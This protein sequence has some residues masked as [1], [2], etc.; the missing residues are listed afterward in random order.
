MKFR[1]LYF[2]SLIGLASTNALASQDSHQAPTDASQKPDNSSSAQSNGYEEPGSNDLKSLNPKDRTLVEGLAN[3]L[4]DANNEQ[5][6]LTDLI[7]AITERRELGTTS[8]RF[9]EINTYKYED[10]EVRLSIFGQQLSRLKRSLP[11]Q[12]EVLRA[13]LIKKQFTQDK[14]DKFIK[15]LR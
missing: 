2:I 5:K 8:S 3:D 4:K 15:S 7:A 9:P 10:L 13:L 6:R 12:E 1:A 11:S 14:A